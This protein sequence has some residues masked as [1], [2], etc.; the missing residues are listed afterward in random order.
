VRDPSGRLLKLLSLLQ[1]PREWSG[2]ELAD[3]LGVTSRTIRR[4][5][6]RLRELGYPVHADRGNVGGYRLQAGAAVPPLLLDDAEAVS[7]AIGLR[8]VATAAITGIEEVSLRALAKV[9]Q[10]LPARLRHRVAALSRSAVTLPPAAGPA[11]DAEVLA[12]LAA[13]CTTR[14][15]VRFAYTTAQGETSRRLVE[16]HRLV[17]SDRRWYLVSYDVERADWRSFRADRITEVHRTGV[18]VPPRDLPGGVDTA[19]WVTA[20]I[21]SQ[22]VRARV[23]LH[24]PIDQ[25]AGLIPA[26]QGELEP[27]DHRSCRLHTHPDTPQHLVHRLT[28][29]PMDYTLLEPSSL[30][31]PLAEIAGRTARA[32]LPFTT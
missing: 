16:P 24:V 4:D 10:V 20:Y 12:A 28:L 31:A 17:V 32:V 21:A 1:T 27:V 8:T 29:L 15:K 30:A 5:I 25:A 26:W 19:T 22:S 3:R 7:I 2:A 23:L 9:E 6:D 11:A 13:A 14:E 18:R